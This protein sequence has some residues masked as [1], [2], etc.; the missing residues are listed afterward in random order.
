MAYNQ[1]TGQAGEELAC[2]Y[3][4][5]KGYKIIE[6]NKRF[7]KNCEIDIIAYDRDTLVFV[8]VKT[9]TSDKCGVPFEAITKQKYNNIRTGLYIY[10]EQM[11]EKKRY[12]IDAVSVML[13]PEIKIE[14][15][16]NIS[17]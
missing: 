9:R 5:K 7:S 12:R 1:K 6:R 17:V 2:R 3:L 13:N 16:K 14:H 8:E 15:I 11:K 10:L 4:I